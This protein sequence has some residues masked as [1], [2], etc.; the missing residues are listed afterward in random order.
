MS[1]YELIYFD[2]FAEEKIRLVVVAADADAANEIALEHM[3]GS[4]NLIS[5]R[6]LR[7]ADGD[8]EGVVSEE[9]VG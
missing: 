7:N 8:G 2:R 5:T 6:V 9:I 3:Q 1:R 4:P